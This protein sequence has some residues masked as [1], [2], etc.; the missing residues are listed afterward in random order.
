MS[1]RPEDPEERW[2]AH[3]EDLQP[4]LWNMHVRREV[5]DALDDAIL[6]RGVPESGAFLEIQRPMY[7]EAQAMTVRRL[8][9]TDSRT[10]SLVT[11][12][13]D[14][15][16]HRHML[17]FN[18][19]LARGGYNVDDEHDLRFARQRFSK[20]SNDGINVS[21][22]YLNGIRRRLRQAG[23]TVAAYVN[24][25]IAHLDAGRESSVTWGDLHRAFD[26]VSE[27]YTEVGGLVTAVHHVPEPSI[28]WNWKRVFWEPLFPSPERRR[29]Q[30]LLERKGRP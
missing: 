2:R 29:E 23:A 25:H 17:T 9:D 15:K 3:F 10:H 30:G 4:Q 5:Y 14:L 24:Q 27:L 1:R 16:R 13:D 19:Y 21:A 28:S 8:V 7:V 18:R 11:L 6:R 22:D 20:M 12:V 26:S